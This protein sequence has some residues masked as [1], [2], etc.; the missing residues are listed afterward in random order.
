M[1]FY[2][3]KKF[4]DGG[5]LY[6]LFHGLANLVEALLKKHKPSPPV[7]R[8]DDEPIDDVD[9]EIYKEEIKEFVQRKMNL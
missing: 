4:K 9:V 1:Y 3:V 7:K 8:E 5:D 6:P 2:V